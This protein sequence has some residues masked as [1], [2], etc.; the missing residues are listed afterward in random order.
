MHACALFTGAVRRWTWHLTPAGCC[1][2]CVALPRLPSPALES[3]NGTAAQS[4]LCSASELRKNSAIFQHCNSNTTEIASAQRIN[5]SFVCVWLYLFPGMGYPVPVIWGVECR[6][7]EACQDIAAN[8]GIL[9]DRYNLFKFQ[10]R[11][12]ILKTKQTPWPLISKRTM[13]TIDRHFSAN[14]SANFWG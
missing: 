8:R 5:V 1:G 7:S 4:L 12:I 6:N 14:F 9:L 2:S 13:R 3:N 11:D 10:E